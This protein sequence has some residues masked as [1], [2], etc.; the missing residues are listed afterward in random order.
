[1]KG[2]IKTIIADK[3]F[4]FITPEDGSKDVFFHAT[5]LQGIEFAQL[6]SG[7]VVTFEVEQSDKG[8]RAV[9]VAVAQE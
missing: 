7:D 4:G 8:P 2:T 6:K 1:M 5:G 3:N 9:N